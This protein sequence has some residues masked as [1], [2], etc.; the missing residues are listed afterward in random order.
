[1]AWWDKQPVSVQEE[2]VDLAAWLKAQDVAPK[3]TFRP[4]VVVSSEEITEAQRRK[5]EEKAEGNEFIQA[6]L[7]WFGK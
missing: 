4:H 5:L 3:K 1:M 7:G 6:F 2:D